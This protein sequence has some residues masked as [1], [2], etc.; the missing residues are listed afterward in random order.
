MTTR[1][2][3]TTR[4]AGTRRRGGSTR[5]RRASSASTLGGAVGAALAGLVIVLVTGLPWWSWALLA[6]VIAGLWLWSAHRRAGGPEAGPDAPAAPP[7]DGANGT[8]GRA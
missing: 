2:R 6:V 8:F 3:R 5:R 7:P 4:R 1:K